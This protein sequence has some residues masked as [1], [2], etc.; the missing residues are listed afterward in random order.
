MAEILNFRIEQNASFRKTISRSDISLFAGI[1]GDFHP[2][3]INVEYRKEKGSTNLLTHQGILVGLLNSV[4]RNQLPGNNFNLLRQ[5][6][7]YLYPVYEGETVEAC[8]EIKNWLPE[9]RLMILRLACYNQD[10]KEVITGEA[11]MIYQAEK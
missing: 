11:V 7:E 6:V 1:S 5:Q 9:K 4:L 10:K 8:V 3:H 2:D